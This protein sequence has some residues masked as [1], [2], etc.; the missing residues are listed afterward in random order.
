MGLCRRAGRGGLGPAGPGLPVSL[1]HRRPSQVRC[2]HGATPCRVIGEGL[3]TWDC[4]AGLPAGWPGGW[5]PA[6]PWLPVSLHHRRPSQ[7]RCRHGAT[8][9]RVIGEG[10]WTWDCVAGLAAGWSGGLGSCWS[11]A[12]GLTASLAF[13]TDRVSMQH[14][15]K[16]VFQRGDFQAG[17]DEMGVDWGY[18][19]GSAATI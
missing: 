11:E 15:T 17:E 10:L 9:Y 7:V 18:V 16:R 8:H 6:G 13:L 1:H 5:G 19:L 14:N 3:W 4:V 2:R 12:P